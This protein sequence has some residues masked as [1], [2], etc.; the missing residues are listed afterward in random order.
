[1]TVG[2]KIT[3]LVNFMHSKRAGDGRNS[4]VFRPCKQTVLTNYDVRPN[5]IGVTQSQEMKGALNVVA[6]CVGGLEESC[7]TTD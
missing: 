2:N 4:C 7:R 1:M 3:V 6:T 5:T